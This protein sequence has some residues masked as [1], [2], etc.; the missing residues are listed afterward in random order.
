[1]SDI[2]KFKEELPSKENFYSSLTDRKISDKKCEHVLNALEKILMKTMKYYH[3]WYLKCAVFLLA[4]VFE[5]FRNNSLKNYGLCP[6]NYLSAPGLSCDAM[7][8]MT[9]LNL[10]LFQ[11]LAC[12]YSLRKVQE[13]ESIIFLIDIAKPTI[14]I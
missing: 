6:S 10:N 2:E 8:K 13:V 14:N 4:D 12:T 7:L 3:D 5:K 9:K 11:I 1:M